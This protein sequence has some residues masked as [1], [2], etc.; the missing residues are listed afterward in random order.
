MTAY[1]YRNTEQRGYR[2]PDRRSAQPMP[3][4]R[5]RFDAKGDPVWEVLTDH[6][7][8]RR[9]DDDTSDPLK[10]LVP[11]SLTLEDDEGGTPGAGFN[12]YDHRGG[13]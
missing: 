6:M 9:E 4:H 12:P 11:E 10:F 7:R 13:E 1:L 3:E 2:G 5:V 8:R